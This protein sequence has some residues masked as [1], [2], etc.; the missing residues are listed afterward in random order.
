MKYMIYYKGESYLL[1]ECHSWQEIENFIREND[2]ANREAHG[3]D[4]ELDRYEIICVKTG[5]NL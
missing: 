3:W 5:G 1:R 2:Q 4:V